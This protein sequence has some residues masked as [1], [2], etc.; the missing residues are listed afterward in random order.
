MPK[1]LITTVP[2]G[3]ND[4][5]P[6]ELVEGAGIEHLINPLNKKLTEYETTCQKTVKTIIQGST[7][8]LSSKI[9]QKKLWR[10][11]GCFLLKKNRH[12]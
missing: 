12:S 5:L 4:R 1:V 9:I 2:Y 11:P 10:G 7:A 8:L 6:L 3:D